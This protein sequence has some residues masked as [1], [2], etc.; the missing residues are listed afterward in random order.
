MLLE[1]E[2]GAAQRHG[3]RASYCALV[4]LIC[5]LGALAQNSIVRGTVSDQTG[6]VVPNATVTLL[7]SAKQAHTI[8]CDE[9]GRYTL[10]NL[11]PGTYAV[12]ASAPGLALAKA[13][14]FTVKP[15]VQILDLVLKVQAVS[16][17]VSVLG[18]SV[19]LVSVDSTNNASAVMLRGSDLQALADDPEDLAEDLQGLAGPSAG[20]NGGSLY[21]DGF[22]GGELPSKDAIR[23]V[24]INENPFSPEYDQL[25]FGRIDVLTKPGADKFRGDAFF[26]IGDSIWNSRDPYAQQKAPFLLREYGGNVGGPLSKRASFLLTTEGAAIDSGSIIHAITLNPQTLQLVNPFTSVFSVPQ[27]RIIVSPRVDYKLSANHS[28]TLRYRVEQSNIRDAGVGGLNLLSMSNHEHSLSHTVQAMETAA[29][30]SNFLNQARFQFYRL[31]TSIL[32]NTTA[33]EIQVLGAFNGGGAQSGPLADTQNDFE[34]QNY[35][36]ITHRTHTVHFGIRLRTGTE[37]ERSEQGFGGTFTFGGGVGPMLNADHQPVLDSSGKPVLIPLQSIDRYQRTL[38]FQELGY[39]PAQIRALGGGAT[40]FAM[41]AG[42]PLVSGSQSDIGVFFGDEWRVRRNLTLSPG[43]RYEWQTG[44]HDWR[45]VAPRL[46]LAWQ[47]GAKFVV[48]AGAGIFYDRFALTDILTTRLYN[49]VTQQQYVINN[50]DFFPNVPAVATLGSAVPSSIQEL[51]PALRAPYTVESTVSLERQLARGTTLAVTYANSHGLHQLRTEDRNAP[52]PGT[53]NPA[54]PGSGIFPLGH[55]G[56]VFAMVSDGLY[57][58][59]QWMANLRSQLNGGFSLFANYAYN[60]AFS[61]TD[62]LNTSPANAYNYA[63]EYGPSLDDV[64]NEAMVGGSFERWNWRISPFLILR[65][66][67]PFDITAGRDLYGDTLFNGRP[68]IAS[69]PNQPGVIATAY[70]LLDPNPSP[71]EP[72]LPR[73]FGRGPGF[74]MLNLRLGKTFEFGAMEGANAGAGQSGKSRSEH[75]RYSLSFSAHLRNILNHNNPGPVIGDITSPLFGRANQ[76]AGSRHLGGT[77][78]L[79]SANNRRLEL[80]TK[81]TF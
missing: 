60:R 10:G 17:N 64:R 65:S 27:R 71:G 59:S 6:A 74:V 44:I 23:E 70:G 45:D 32:P 43:V 5:S 58:Q 75:R 8:T 21:V 68:G 46:G 24:H 80:Q 26:N 72:L 36:T 18:E 48:R 25:G 9:N 78:F 2:H 79:E 30:G 19:P 53:F 33:P 50:P 22:S 63:G 4:L 34:I 7:N 61:N 16:E 1:R 41:D 42:N 77:G 52:L 29:I 67:A 35:T 76:S 54:V 20:P 57:N 14:R 13:R 47:P 31:G 28:V 15:G 39:S 11:A 38:L 40:Q 3:S 55:P 12:R 51:S 81:F 37:A 66:G 69:N 49:G 62:G 56:A 73:N